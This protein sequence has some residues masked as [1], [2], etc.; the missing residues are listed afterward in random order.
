MWVVG[1]RKM[2]SGP[3]YLLKRGR[4]C[5]SRWP[6]RGRESEKVFNMFFETFSP[7]CISVPKVQNWFHLKHLKHPAGP[8]PGSAINIKITLG[9]FLNWMQSARAREPSFHIFPPLI[10]PSTW[11]RPFFL[12]VS[13]ISGLWGTVCL[14][15]SEKNHCLMIWI[16][17]HLIYYV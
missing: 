16:W 7:L 8:L 12:F 17:Q 10:S 15:R 2:I 11:R 6:K 14:Q 3:V 13:R 9:L 4:T 5:Y 1:K